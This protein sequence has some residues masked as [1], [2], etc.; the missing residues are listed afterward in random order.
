[1]FATSL[2]GPENLREYKTNEEIFLKPILEK[3]YKI[4]PN[5]QINASD[6]LLTK[7]TPGPVIL[8]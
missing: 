1:M 6:K 7:F 8:P 5:A 2:I 4:D 3:I